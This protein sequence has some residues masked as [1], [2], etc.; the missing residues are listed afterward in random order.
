[1]TWMTFSAPTGMPGPSGRE[2]AHTAAATREPALRGS[3]GIY[4]E[5]DAIESTHF[6]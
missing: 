1:M 2:D 5:P 6:C 4:Y 3:P